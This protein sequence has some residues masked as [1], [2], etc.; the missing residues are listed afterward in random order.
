MRRAS[1]APEFE[2]ETFGIHREPVACA[3]GPLKIIAEVARRRGGG[4]LLARA[5][6]GWAV[7]SLKG[8]GGLSKRLLGTQPPPA[9][10]WH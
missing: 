7:R 8:R 1:V 4:A 6:A 3:W 2:D 10:G 9:P 5:T